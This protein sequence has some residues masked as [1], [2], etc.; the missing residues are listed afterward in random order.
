MFYNTFLSVALLVGAAT[1]GAMTAASAVDPISSTMTPN[2]TTA[3]TITTPG[4]SSLID[5][6]KAERGSTNMLRGAPQPPLGKELKLEDFFA[7]NHNG[8]NPHDRKLL[9]AWLSIRSVY[10]G[11]YLY[12]SPHSD[13]MRFDP[14]ECT[15]LY[16]TPAD[17]GYFLY[18]DERCMD[19]EFNAHAAYMGPCHGG[20]NQKWHFYGDSWS[21][22]VVA[23]EHGQKCLDLD[24]DD[25]FQADALMWDCH[26]G[27]NQHF[28]V[29]F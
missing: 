24:L 10:N 2:N 28:E 21:N 3:T 23:S 22:V 18:S 4:P 26:G 11:D 25:S 8:E 16:A 1:P 5:P 17:T 14:Q 6:V 13:A 9:Y 19:H 15:Q 29:I 7:A 27:T 20:N 12:K